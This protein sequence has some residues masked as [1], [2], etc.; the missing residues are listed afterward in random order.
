[1]SWGFRETITQGKVP[2]VAA[3]VLRSRYHQLLASVTRAAN[4]PKSAVDAVNEAPVEL[5]TWTSKIVSSTACAT[6]IRPSTK[7]E[8]WSRLTAAVWFWTVPN[9]G[10]PPGKPMLPNSGEAPFPAEARL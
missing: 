6:G 10:A 8:P 2:G 5:S 4:F 9:V 7:G 3:I 1:K